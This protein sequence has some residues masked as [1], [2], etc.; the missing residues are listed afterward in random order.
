MPI[1]MDIENDLY[2]PGHIDRRDA[3]LEPKMD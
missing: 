2:I 3:R 1:G